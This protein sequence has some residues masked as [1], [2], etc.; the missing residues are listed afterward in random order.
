MKPTRCSRLTDAAQ[1]QRL[2]LLCW[3]AYAS[4]Y[5]GRYNYSAV[6]GAITAEGTLRLGMAGAVSTGYFVC[7]AIGQIVFGLLSP[8]VSPYLLIT[9]GLSGSGLC[10]LG[11]STAAPSWMIAFWAA[12]GVFQAMIWPPIVR[13]FAE[14]MPLE[15]QKQACVSINSTTPAGTL[16]AYAVSAVLLAFSRWNTV[17]FFCGILLLAIAGFFWAGTASLR[18]ATH[19]LP[20]ERPVHTEKRRSFLPAAGLGA[21]LIPVIL[22]GGLKDGVTSWFPSML[23]SSFALRPTFSAAI[24]MILPVVNLSGAYLSG[25]LDAHYFHNELKTA[26]ALFS[27][28][29][30]CLLALPAAIQCSL[31]LAVL[32]LAITTAS[33]LGVNTMFINVLPVKA[34]RSSGAAA[35]SGALNAITYL[36][37][38]AS[39]WG[40]GRT[41]EQSGWHAVFRLW[42]SMA[43]L[44]LLVTAL[45]ANRWAQFLRSSEERN[46]K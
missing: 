44:S 13:L 37:A 2:Y 25:W 26:A 24:S 10:N 16:A 43:I 20:Q 6:M 4:A 45:L 30:L 21:L 41:A 32:L 22:H 34:G 42:I 28:A 11:M 33:M 46:C 12:N 7:Y 39:T 14:S 3:V 29:A 15:H 36:G 17:F 8:Y 1:G 38:A 23:Q 27:V 31:S 19:F 5:V 40:I 18:S 9:L 35:L